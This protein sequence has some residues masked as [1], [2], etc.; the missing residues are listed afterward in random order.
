MQ[1]EF[2]VIVFSS[3]TKIAYGFVYTHFHA[4]IAKV[5]FLFKKVFQ[6]RVQHLGKGKILYNSAHVE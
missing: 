5:F 3:S 2:T 1:P 4:K 6:M